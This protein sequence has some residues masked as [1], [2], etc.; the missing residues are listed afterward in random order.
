MRRVFSDAAISL[1]A[2]AVLFVAMASIDDR[3]RDY[4]SLSVR[5][6]SAA[7]AGAGMVH[8]GGVLVLAVRDLSLAHAPLT[9]FVVA[10]VVLVLFMLRT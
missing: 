2:L 9:I 1:A 4:V 8:L 3:V 6:A 10:A 7:D 5:D